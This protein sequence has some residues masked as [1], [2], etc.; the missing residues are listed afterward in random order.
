MRINNILFDRNAIFV[1]CLKG[2]KGRYVVLSTKV[3]QF[4]KLY[5][6]QH[7]PKFRLFESESSGEYSEASM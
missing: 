1:R 3:T 4:L 2:K 5:L 7:N 6:G